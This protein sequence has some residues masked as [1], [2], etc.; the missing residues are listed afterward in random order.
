MGRQCQPQ[1][2][3]KI[4]PGAFFDRAPVKGRDQ[5][6]QCPIVGNHPG[7]DVLIQFSF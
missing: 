1:L 4:R 2:T 3:Q 5:I 7:F 6:Q